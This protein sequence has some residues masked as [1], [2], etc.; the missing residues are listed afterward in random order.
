MNESPE[1]PSND[2]ESSLGPNPEESKEAVTETETPPGMLP[3]V[4]PFFG[5]NAFLIAAVP[6]VIYLVGT[7]FGGYLEKTRKTW[8]EVLSSVEQ[9]S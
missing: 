2:D 4:E 9:S 1:N 5:K 6:F 8:M 3:L 7:G